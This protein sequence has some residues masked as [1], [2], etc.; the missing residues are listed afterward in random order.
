MNDRSGAAVAIGSDGLVVSPEN[1]GPFVARDADITGIALPRLAAAPRTDRLWRSRL[2][3][4]DPGALP[5]RWLPP[6]T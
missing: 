1:G 4:Y 3:T 2:T 6:A 5:G